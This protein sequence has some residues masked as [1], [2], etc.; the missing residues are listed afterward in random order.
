[1]TTTY[2]TPTLSK[3]RRGT[4]LGFTSY[5]IVAP[6][7]TGLF[8]P[9]TIDLS[10]SG[11]EEFQHP[12]LKGNF[13]PTVVLTKSGIV[14][15]SVARQSSSRAA[16]PVSATRPVNDAASKP[17]VY[18]MNIF[19]LTDFKEHDG[20]YVTFGGGAKGGKITGKGTIRTATKD[21]TSRILK[22]FITEIENLVEKKVKII[23]CDNGTEFKNRVMNEFCEEKDQ[24]G[25][26]DEKL[27]K[28]I[29][30][31]YSTISKAF[32]VYNIRTRKVEEKLH[33]TFLKN[34]PMIIGGG[35][36]WLF[37]IDALSK[38]I[39]YAPVF[40]G[41]NSNDFAC[42]GASFDAGQSSMETGSSQDYILMPLWKYNSLF[43]SSSQALDGHNKDKHGPS[44]ASK[45]DNQERPYAKSSTKTVN[46]IKPINTATSTYAKYTNDPPM[47]DLED[48]GIF[49]DAYD[50]RDKGAEADYNNLETGHRQEEGIDYDEVFAPVAR[51]DAIKLFLVY[52]SFMDFTVYQMDVKSAFFMALLKRR[53]WYETLS[54][55][56]LDNGFRRGTIDKTLFIK[57]IKDDILLVQVYVDDIIFGSTNSVKSA[58]TP[59]EKHKPLSNDAAG[60]GVDVHLYRVDSLS[61]S[62]YAGA[63]LDRKSTTG[64]C[65]S[66]WLQALVCLILRA[67]IKGRLGL[68]DAVEYNFV[69]LVPKLVLLGLKL[70]VYLINDGHADLVQH[71]DKK[72]LAIPGQTAVGK[73]LS[74][75]LMAG[76]LPKTT[77]TTLLKPLEC[78]GFKHIVDFLNTN[79]IKYTLTVSPTIYTSCIKQFWTTLKIKTVNDN[80]QLQALI[81][82]KKVVI[83]EAFIRHDL[84]LNDAEGTSCLPNAMIFEELARMRYGKPSN[85]K[86]LEAVVPFYMFPRFVQVFVNHQIG[87]MSQHT[88]IYVNPSL[89]KKVFANMK[90]VG[91]GFSGVVTSLF[92]TM[93]IQPVK[94]VGDLLTAN[95]DTPIPDASSSSQPQRKHKPRRKEKKE[96][97][98]PED[99]EISNLKARIKLLEDKDK[100]TAKLSGDDAP[101]KGRSLE[102]GEK[103]GVERIQAVSV[104]PIAEVSTIGV[105]TGSGLVPTVNAIFTAA[106]VVTPYSR[107]PREI[108]AKDKGGLDR[109]N[110]MIAKHL[111][112][113]EKAAAK[114]T[115]GE[116]IELIN[117]LV[118]YQDHHA[119][120]LKYQDQ[121]SKPLSKKQQRE[122]YMSVLKSHSGWKTKHFRDHHAKILKYQAQQSKPLSKKE[123]SKFYMSVLRSH[124]GWKTKHFRGM[125]LEEIREKF[126]PVWKQ[127]KDFVLM[128]SKE[129]G[130]RVKRKGLKLE[131]RSAKKMK[132]SKDVS[133]EDL[134]EM[135]QLVPMEEVYVEALQFDREDLNQLWTLVKE[136]LTIRQ[137]SSDKEK[138][139]WVELK[140]LCEPDF[141]DQLWTHTQALMHDPL[142]WR[143][144]DACGGTFM[145]RRLEE[146]YDLI[147]NMTAHHNDW[148]TSA[149]QSESSNSM[150]SSFDTE[151]AALKAKMAEINKN[152]MRVLQVNQQVKA[153]TPNCETCGGPH[154]YTDCPVTIG[155]TQNVNTAGAY[156]GGNSYQPQGASHGQNPPPSYQA[157]AY[158][159]LGFQAPVHQ[160]QI[161]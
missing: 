129:E 31:G 46:T 51:I 1:M 35:P 86:N 158:Q 146:C 157:P 148:D 3:T 124:S 60:T 37:Y 75:L 20:G 76:S 96:R 4:G 117:E 127:I 64:G 87:D 142:D 90:R 137:S 105:P 123:Q 99:L 147:E 153:V 74:N 94:E 138:E 112:E 102:T 104:P 115:I 44:Q 11:L 121:Q 140:R 50:D 41:T 97:K 59:M 55:Y 5:N 63:S 95:Q 107:R 88:G 149:Q 159:A 54:T 45:S 2:N 155:Q 23:R 133:K 52:P 136:T 80:V 152:F 114:L 98:A 15:I 68:V 116:K 43:Y 156:Q 25:K 62:D 101:I 118:K 67:W 139:L 85:K 39:N 83:T 61:D 92:D 113:Y 73:E 33:I 6:P 154:S 91:T 77:L 65:F 69:L 122:F 134:K 27:D 150:T 160:P 128:A 49:D 132:T 53:A 10:N 56:L 125:T 36:E 151:I 26:F 70:K 78:D 17:L 89:T 81:N 24:L 47:P 72:E 126:I 34:K 13:A 12:K 135:M 141:E 16:A 131:L 42:K 119:K 48:V 100:G 103:A 144:Y 110:E 145:K 22:S 106:S 21:E 9:P 32:R 30:I 161:P 111:H 108:L 82:G 109:S 84:K 14:P 8:A 66:F 38:S 57:Q 7:P 19:Y 40:T 58:I 71:T 18:D 143:L 93:M 29:F 28:G 120:I 79:Q 130:E